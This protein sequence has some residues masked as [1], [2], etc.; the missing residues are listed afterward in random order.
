MQCLGGALGCYVHDGEVVGWG[1]IR[2]GIVMRRHGWEWL[3]VGCL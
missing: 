1:R 3:E 2:V